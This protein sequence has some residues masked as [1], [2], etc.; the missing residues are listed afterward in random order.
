M[1]FIPEYVVTHWWQQ[2]LHNQSALRFKARLLFT[3]GVVVVSVPYHL[4]VSELLGTGPAQ[5]HPG[6]AARG[7]WGRAGRRAAA[8]PWSPRWPGSCCSTTSSWPG[9]TNSPSPRGRTCS[10]CWRSCWSRSRSA[11]WWTWPPGGPRRPPRR[12]PRPPSCPPWPAA[13]CAGSSR[14]PRCSSRSGK[15]SGWTAS[16]CWNATRTRPRSGTAARPGLLAD[17]R[18]RRR[19]TLRRPRRRRGATSRSTTS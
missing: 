4:G 11:W 17:R 10:P 14:C 3:P 18:H 2:L 6:D 9:S 19:T 7:G 8:R 15:R 13:S 12:R 16:P 5:R 1:V